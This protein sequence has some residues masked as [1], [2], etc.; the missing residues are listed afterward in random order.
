MVTTSLS[1]LVILS[2]HFQVRGD[3]EFS[4]ITFPEHED[5]FIAHVGRLNM[6]ASLNVRL[7]LSGFVQYSSLE[8][9]SALNFRLRYNPVDGNDLYLVYN[10]AMNHGP[11]PGLQDYPLSDSRSIMVKYVHTFRPH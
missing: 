1:S 3:Y 6:T 11:L 5:P 2:R 8:K 10:E 7:S 4:Y 9:I